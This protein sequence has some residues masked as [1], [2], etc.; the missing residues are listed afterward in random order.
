MVE[1]LAYFEEWSVRPGERVRMA[2]STRR[3]R[4]HATLE[5]IVTGPGAPGESKVGTIPRPDV[6]D[7]DIPGR[8]QETAVGSYAA[9][10]LA[11]APAPGGLTLHAWIWPTVPAAAARQTVWSLDDGALALVLEAGAL[12]LEVAGAVVATSPARMVARRWYSVAVVLGADAASLDVAE[13]GAYTDD[14]S[15]VTAGPVVAL[16]ALGRLLLAG[17]TIDPV[18]SPVAPYD[19]KIDRPT[20]HRRALAAD[21][22]AALRAG[23]GPAPDVSWAT[24]RDFASRTLAAEGA[25]DGVL[26]N[27]VERAVTGHDWDGR[28][29]SYLETPS[30]YGALQFH[31]DDMVESGWD[32]DLAFDLPAD[33]PSGVY[34]VRLEA[35]DAVERW[36]LFVRGA[37][38]QSVDTL[39]LLPTNTYLAYANERL[40]VLDFS[41]VMMHAQTPTADDLYLAGEPALGRSCYDTHTDGSVCRYS[42]RRRPI[43]QVRPGFP[44][45]LTGSYR[46][47]PVDLY[48]VE[49]LERLGRPY[50]VATDEDLER[51]GR[52]LLDRYEVV[53]TGSHPEY[54]TRHGRGILDG[55][56]RDGGGLMYV[57]GNGFYWVTSRDPERPWL[58]EVRRDN[59]GTRCWDAPAGERGH[60]YSAEQGGIWK[61][62]GLGPHGFVGIGFCAE[63][64]SQGCG[65]R[66]RPE[67]REG[68][69][70]RLFAGI[71]AEVIGDY[72][73]VL[74]GAAGDEIDRYDVALGSP[75][76][77]VHLA[78]STGVGRE[79]IHVVEEQNV[80]LPDQ[81]GDAL[82]DLVRSDIVYF[83]VGKGA[84]FSIGSM[85]LAGSLA[86]NDFDNDVARL[87]GNALG[88]LTE[89]RG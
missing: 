84:V 61:N 76:H 75:P 74:G 59:S 62:R 87:L 88:V 55:Y 53:V 77:A 52:A 71:D 54:W 8:W 42:S 89:G 31:S 40:A 33:L 24:D 50:H 36:P 12:A 49:W 2:T 69:G 79:Y 26:V 56:L 1:I 45:W 15:A 28:S 47:F 27:G 5:R 67:S 17:R 20:L 39:L 46:H 6:L 85:T 4:L 44:S 51:E 3:E 16:F 60:V 80:G 83:T 30:Q 63:G 82:P 35:G 13:V 10:P 70:A 18:G 65:Y 73:H 41:T 32:Y 64:W 9:L 23:A 66:R 25:P 57:G 43:L 72:G 78:S 68:I 19:G 37:V 21:E 14:T 29:D 86:W 58:I 34:C 48:F 81:G 22:I 38:D 7:V 11:A